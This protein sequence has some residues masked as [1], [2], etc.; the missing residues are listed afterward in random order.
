MTSTPST[1]APLT[2]FMREAIEIAKRHRNREIF[3]GA[4]AEGYVYH[5]ACK[6]RREVTSST[7]RALIRRGLAVQVAKPCGLFAVRLTDNA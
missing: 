2:D 1:T 4:L 7:L 6:R 3:A 5:G